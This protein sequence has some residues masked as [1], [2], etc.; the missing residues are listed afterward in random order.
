MEYWL[1]GGVW[2]EKGF[3]M[4]C[5]LRVGLWLEEGVLMERRLRLRL[6]GPLVEE[7]LV[8]C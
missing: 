4:G 8:G 7:F 1:R 2:L 6:G 3:L 5:P